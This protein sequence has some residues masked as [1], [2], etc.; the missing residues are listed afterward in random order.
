MD[1]LRSIG[2]TGVQGVEP[3]VVPDGRQAAEGL[4]SVESV[5]AIYGL[6]LGRGQEQRQVIARLSMSGGED[7]ALACLLA[8]P[9]Q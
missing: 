6:G 9:L 3:Q 8:Y 2:I 4:A 1:N 5:T 7:L